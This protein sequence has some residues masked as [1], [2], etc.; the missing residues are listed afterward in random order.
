MTACFAERTVVAAAGAVKIPAELPLWQAALLGCG[1]VTGIG[2][3]RNAGRVARRRVG[4]RDRMRRR[5]PPG[6]RGRSARGRRADRRSR[7]RRRRNSSW[8][9]RS[10]R[11]TRSTRRSQVPSRSARPD[12]TAEPSTHSRWSAAQRRSASPGTLFG[13]AARWSSSA[14]SPRGVDVSVPGIE[15]L[16]D[17]TLRGTY[18]GSGDAAHD[19]PELAALAVGAT[20][21]SPASSRTPPTSTA[22]RPHSTACAAAKAPAPS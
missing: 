9:A 21:T 22:S 19:L 3:V 15:F 12:R 17:K 1:V 2:A 14:S 8:R 7:S 10:A 13:P 4:L 11:R 18:Y 6:D 20:S 5:R 16:S